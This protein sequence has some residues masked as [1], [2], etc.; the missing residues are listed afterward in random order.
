[1]TTLTVVLLLTLL[2]MACCCTSSV[3][4]TSYCTSVPSTLRYTIANNVNAA[5]LDGATGTGT[6][7]TGDWLF[8][9][10][11]GLSCAGG[12]PNTAGC[13]PAL[14]CSDLAFG[15]N[16][17]LQCSGASSGANIESS[18]SGFNLPYNPSDPNMSLTCSPFS[19][20][21]R[22]VQVFHATVTLAHINCVTGGSNDDNCYIDITFTG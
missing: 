21:M 11:S 19:L 12:T 5:C 3:N 18:T 8:P 14:R 22:H 1:M 9:W 4:C 17:F 15:G 10:S 20:T 13:G 6:Y 16:P 2:G 7:V